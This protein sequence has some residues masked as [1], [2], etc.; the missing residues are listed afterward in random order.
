MEELGS[1]LKGNPTNGAIG[2]I[3]VLI[4]LCELY[5]LYF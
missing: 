1:A 5:V 2:G 4:D 3:Y